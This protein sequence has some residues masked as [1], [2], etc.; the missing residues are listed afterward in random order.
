MKKAILS[1]ICIAVLSITMVAQKST[2]S[3]K[4]P[5]D[6]KVMGGFNSSH[7]TTEH[8][9]WKTQGRVGYQFGASVLVGNKFYFEP[10]ISYVTM[11]KDVWDSKNPDS[12][13][14]KNNISSI[15][16]PA[17][18]GYHIIGNEETLADLRLFAGFGASFITNV[19]NDADDLDKDDFKI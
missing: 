2:E 19:N 4:T 17:K 12:T 9:D 14:F 5:I 1:I 18:I 16:I 13:S 8:I 7:L 15:R 3:Q 10:G 6:I 11:T